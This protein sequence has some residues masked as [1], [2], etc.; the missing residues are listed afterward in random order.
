MMM[1]SEAGQG[2][3]L[4]RTRETFIQMGLILLEDM[5]Y[6]PD[7]QIWLLDSVGIN[8]GR[9]VAPGHMQSSMATWHSG[10]GDGFNMELNRALL[11]IVER[12]EMEVTYRL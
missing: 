4:T 10:R 8:L 12:L 6:K 1:M 3:T 2:D 9:N 11:Y 5:L 7:V